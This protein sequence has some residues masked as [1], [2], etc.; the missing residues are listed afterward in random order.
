[1]EHFTKFNCLRFSVVMH[2]S[3]VRI[4][5]GASFRGMEYE[6]AKDAQGASTVSPRKQ[7]LIGIMVLER[8]K[9]RQ[10]FGMACRDV[11]ASVTT[12]TG[13]K[14]YPLTYD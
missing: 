4:P 3:I 10:K 5:V 8:L 14:C 2:P 7:R 12:V 6:G 9:S 11:R 13:S 1:M